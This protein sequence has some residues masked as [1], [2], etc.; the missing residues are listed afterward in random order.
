M[1]GDSHRSSRA[2]RR[3]RCRARSCLLG[4]VS[5]IDG[6]LQPRAGHF[7]YGLAHSATRVEVFLFATRL[8]AGH[9]APEARRGR[10]RAWHGVAREV[11]RTGAAALASARRFA[12]FNTHWARRVVRNGPVVLIVSDGW[13]R[14]DPALL[15]QE[16]ARR[17]PQLPA[18]DLA[19]PAA[20]FRIS[21]S[22]SHG[23]CRRRCGTWT[24]SFRR[25]ISSV[26]EQ[27]ANHLRAL[28]ARDTPRR[29][30][31]APPVSAMD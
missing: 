14:G 10:R 6:A 11:R 1:I 25:T 4:D 23:A 28:P 7:V 3:R 24:T 17:P 26:L 18:A 13:D 30:A 20:R 22:R 27:L 9:A 29:V 16:L 31:R 19:Q 12:P 2:T 21:T 15:K 8:D 5:W